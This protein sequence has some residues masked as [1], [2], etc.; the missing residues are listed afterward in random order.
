[1]KLNKILIIIF[2]AL[3]TII[4]FYL[5]WHVKEPIPVYKPFESTSAYVVHKAKLGNPI[6]EV[7][8]EKRAEEIAYGKR[9]AISLKSLSKYYV[10]D[11]SKF[12]FREY[13]FHVDENKS[14]MGS[15]K[16]R[17]SYEKI[18]YQKFEHG[19]IIGNFTKHPSLIKSSGYGVLFILMDDGEYDL[20]GA[21]QSSGCIG[22]TKNS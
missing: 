15:E 18:Y 8:L 3:F 19:I 14:D 22:V 17:C 5:M 21:E 9:I 1:M 2:I 7:K 11:K 13:N 6:S 10:L 20:E 12:G 4:G 16:W